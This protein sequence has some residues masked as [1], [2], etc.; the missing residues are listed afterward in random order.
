MIWSIVQEWLDFGDENPR[1]FMGWRRLVGRTHPDDMKC[2][3]VHS[4]IQKVKSMK[5]LEVYYCGKK[6]VSVSIWKSK[7][8]NNGN[9]KKKISG[10]WVI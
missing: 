10:S 2:H 6:N 8:D 7:H 3:R 5:S 4:S 9:C 1:A